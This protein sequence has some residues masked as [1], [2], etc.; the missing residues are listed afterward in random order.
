MCVSG[1]SECKRKRECCVKERA[2]IEC[3]PTVEFGSTLL[4]FGFCFKSSISDL[5]GSQAT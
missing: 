2:D 4:L 5:V 1:V 3:S